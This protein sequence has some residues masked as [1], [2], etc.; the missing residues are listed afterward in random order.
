MTSETGSSLVLS[1]EDGAVPFKLKKLI[2]TG[3]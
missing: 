3:G 2:G 1:L